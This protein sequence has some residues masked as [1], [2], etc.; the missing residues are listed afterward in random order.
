MLSPKIFF[1]YTQQKQKSWAL[2]LYIY[3]IPIF[4]SSTGGIPN[5]ALSRFPSMLGSSRSNRFQHFFF[6][7]RGGEGSTIS[8]YSKR[9]GLPSTRTHPSGTELMSTT[10]TSAPN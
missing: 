6:F 1:C 8:K 7:F 2:L 3:S 4:H 5:R 9:R 10:I